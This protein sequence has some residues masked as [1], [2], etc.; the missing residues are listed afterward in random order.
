MG[1][2]EEEVWDVDRPVGGWIGGGREWNME[3]KKYIKSEIKFKK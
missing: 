3:C 2:G 1:W